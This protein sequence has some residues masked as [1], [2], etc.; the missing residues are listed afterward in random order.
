MRKFVSKYISINL[1][2]KQIYA[3]DGILSSG[4]KYRFIYQDAMPDIVNGPASVAR[5]ILQDRHRAV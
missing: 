4:H 3:T 2:F 1:T 5:D